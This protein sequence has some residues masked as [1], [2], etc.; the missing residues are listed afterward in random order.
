MQ[1]KYA[2]A[3]RL[4]AVNAVVRAPTLTLKSWLPTSIINSFAEPGWLGM[5]LQ[6]VDIH[7]YMK[8]MK[9]DI[10]L[11]EKEKMLKRNYQTDEDMHGTR[12]RPLR[13]V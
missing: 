12:I 5:S 4:N 1:P 11:K 6:S 3:P 10:P 13:I 8:Q 7:Q 9:E 2:S